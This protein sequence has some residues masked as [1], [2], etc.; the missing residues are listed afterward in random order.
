VQCEKRLAYTIITQLKDAEERNPGS[1][2]QTWKSILGPD[3]ADP[4]QEVKSFD[5]L[6][7]LMED[8]QKVYDELAH[9]ATLPWREFDAKYPDFQKRAEGASPVAKI[10]LPAMKKV[11]AAQRHS[12]ARLAMLL[13]AIAVVEGGEEKLADIKDPFGDGPF[14][15]RKLDPGFE[16]SSKLTEDGKPVTLVIGQKPTAPKP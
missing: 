3:V 16:L 13:A 2:R 12:E 5:E 9:L 1:W 6:V 11:V 8:Y 4:L 7:E 14:A 15:Y 10:L